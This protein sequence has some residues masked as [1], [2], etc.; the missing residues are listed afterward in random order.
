VNLSGTKHG[1]ELVHEYCL[2]EHSLP[3][4]LMSGLPRQELEQ[5]YNLLQTDL[6]ISKPFKIS[7]LMERL[8]IV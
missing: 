4:I 8:Q 1:I 7:Q 3:Y 2:G 5:K 6:L